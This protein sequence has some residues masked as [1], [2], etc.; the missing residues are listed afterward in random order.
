MRQEKYQTRRIELFIEIQFN[1]SK[2]I[3]NFNDR[4]ALT[5]YMVS[6]IYPKACFGKSNSKE[7]SYQLKKILEGLG[8]KSEPFYR[9]PL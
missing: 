1:I 6:M 9:R 4:I 2:N 3:K 7:K 5:C 8:I